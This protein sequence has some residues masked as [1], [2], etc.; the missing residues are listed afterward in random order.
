MEDALEIRAPRI[1]DAAGAAAVHYRSWVAT[2]TPLLRPDQCDRLTL[3]ERIAHWEWLLR[4]QPPHMGALLAVRS[5]VIVGLVEWEIGVDVD[6]SVG[7]I[8][9]IHVALEERGRG[10][11]WRLLDASVEALRGHGVRRAILWV[12]EDNAT[13]RAFYERQG[14]AWDGTRLERSLGGFPDFPSV[15]EVRYALDLS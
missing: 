2:Y 3:A 4:S 7:E 5:G 12:I 9:A 11:G 10:V 13:A 1:D 15:I 8:H 6:T 14:W